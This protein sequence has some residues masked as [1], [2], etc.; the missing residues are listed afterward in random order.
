[1][2]LVCASNN[3][4]VQAEQQGHVTGSTFAH[5]VDEWMKSERNVEPFWDYPRAMPLFKNDLLQFEK[6]L[7]GITDDPY[8]AF[9]GHRIF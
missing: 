6:N 5:E 1:M 8:L 4:I 2:H 9:Q 3:I 7:D